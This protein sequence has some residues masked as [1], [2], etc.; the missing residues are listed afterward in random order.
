MKGLLY[1]VEKV[2]S[3]KLEV[4]MRQ[5]SEERRKKLKVVFL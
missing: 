3:F 1:P 4:E 5:K 2:N